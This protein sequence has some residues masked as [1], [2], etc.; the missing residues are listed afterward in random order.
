MQAAL[1]ILYIHILN[2]IFYLNIYNY[3]HKTPFHKSDYIYAVNR[4][5][6]MMNVGA[7]HCRT[8]RVNVD[9]KYTVMFRIP[10]DKSLN[11]YLSR[12]AGL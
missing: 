3:A 5:N 11:V 10:L 7:M 1:F 2:W 4:T 9:F 6:F 12:M 8:S